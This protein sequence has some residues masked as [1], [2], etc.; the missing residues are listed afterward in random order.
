MQTRP[1]G[2]GR[3]EA[4]SL[5]P[6]SL[7]ASLRA[8]SSLAD[9]EAWAR[10]PGTEPYATALRKRM[11]ELQPDL[12]QVALLGDCTLDFL[13]P[14]LGWRLLAESLPRRVL[15]GG[16][17]Q[18]LQDLQSLG[19]SV[20]TVV[21]VPWAEAP[22]PVEDALDYWQTAWSLLRQRSCKVVQVGYDWSQPSSLGH[23]VAWA[24]EWEQLNQAL[25]RE[26]P[27]GT[28]FIDLGQIS[29]WV[30]RRSFYDRRSYFWT[31]QP[32]SD[33]GLSEL[34]RHLAAALRTLETGPK[35][36]L[37]LDLDNTLWGGEVGE[38]GWSH[39]ELTGP[40]GEGYLAFQ[41][42]LK[43][44]RQRGVLLAIASKNQRE[45]AWQALQEHP[46]MVLRP[47]DFV[48][49]E[50]HWEPKSTSLV[51]LSER[52][53]L[54]LDSFVFFDDNPREREEIRTL[55]PQVEVIEVSRDPVD[56][57]ADLH[58]S[59]LF[60]TLAV[61]AEDRGRTELYRSEAQRR[62]FQ[63]S[64]EDYLAQLQMEGRVVGLEPGNLSRVVQLVAKTNQFN[65]TTRRHA[66]AQLQ[67]WSD[68]PAVYC[69]A[70]ELRDRFG[71]LGLVAVLI[72]LPG[73][74]GYRI[75][76]WLMSCRVLQRTVEIFFFEH[77]VE[78]C[79]Q[80]GQSALW[81]DY[82]PTAKN[83]LVADLLPRL[84]F[85]ETAGE[86][87]RLDL[88]QRTELPTYVMPWTLPG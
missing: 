13:A 77:L 20:R 79:R 5:E 10:Q 64:V 26:M 75:D 62:Q 69:R 60:E 2:L 47:E 58:R 4:V 15:V 18:A 53:G 6:L 38:L 14:R 37:V 7:R 63:G 34:A 87:W 1:D 48:D 8:C 33:S 27:A 70:L 25:R 41:R 55:L 67:S 31:K 84:G 50:I 9:L 65:L 59:L 57:G 29:G 28:F 19:E 39:I 43:E 40:H 54:G 16:Y 72:A 22:P 30:G 81:A 61:T 78:F 12:P 45:V 73:P 44:L 21:L 83:A 85:V 74:A 35:K 17:G 71:E 49:A 36:V 32:F 23:A 82:V 76:T 86:G 80:Q 68:D 88:E 66:S 51:R 42:T 3:A 46:E 52:L 11:G 56:Y 24:A